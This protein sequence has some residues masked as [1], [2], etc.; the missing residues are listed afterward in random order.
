MAM[1]DEYR[2]YLGREYVS[3]ADCCPAHCLN[4][5]QANISRLIVHHFRE[6]F[7][8]CLPLFLMGV[9]HL[10]RIVSDTIIFSCANKRIRFELELYQE[11][12]LRRVNAFLRGKCDGLFSS[13][14][15]SI[16]PNPP[17]KSFYLEKSVGQIEKDAY[18]QPL[19][20]HSAFLQHHAFGQ[21]IRFFR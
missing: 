8:G 12:I 11:D 2:E 18:N 7:D 16:R 17:Q 19:S 15:F 13:I 20:M 14:Q 4:S 21:N 9:F 5:D 10:D 6:I 3:L 1:K